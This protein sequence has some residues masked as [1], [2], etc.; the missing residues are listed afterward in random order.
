MKEEKLGMAKGMR[1][2]LKMYWEIAREL[3]RN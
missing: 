2:R 3:K 1:A